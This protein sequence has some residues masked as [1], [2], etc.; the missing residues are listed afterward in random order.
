MDGMAEW[1]SRPLDP[2]YP[3]MF[4]DCIHVKIR[5]GQV[6]NRPIYVA[7]GVTVDGNRDILGLVG[8][9]TAAEGA[10]YWLGVLTELKN[11]GVPSVHRRVR[12]AQG[13]ARLDRA[14]V[15]KTIVQTC[16]VHLLRNT[17]RLASRTRLGR[18]RQGPPTRL[19]GSVG[20]RPRSS[21]FA[22]FSDK[23]EKRYPAIIRLWTNA[24][25]EFVPFLEYDTEIRQVIYTTN[26]IESLQR[27]DP[28][29]V[30]A[31]GHFPTEQAALKCLYLV[32]RSSTRPA[33]AQHAGRTVGSPHSTPSPSC[34]KAEYSPP[35]N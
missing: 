1:Q 12:R 29:G 35:T 9:P 31:R 13:S 19:H 4:I 23:W 5:D 21:R 8:R 28:P 6:A 20:R 11:R 15:A 25:A 22:E 17:F 16:V 34:S 32:I 3:V 7:I 14:S 10:K 24:W 26:A 2:V 33:R 18:D 30:K 27:P